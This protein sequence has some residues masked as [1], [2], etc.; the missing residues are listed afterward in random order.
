MGGYIQVST[1][2]ERREDAEE[3]AKVLIE[4][5][6]AG[7]VQMVG[8]V[9]STYRWKGKVETAEEWLILV[10]SREELYGELEKA[11]EE[12]HPYE[13]PEI[14]ATPIVAGNKGYLEWLSEVLGPP[15]EQCAGDIRT[16]GRQIR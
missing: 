5:R 1:T 16:M 12:V 11:I 7:C 9:V 8:P 4:R 14:I 13:T 6:L 10:K 15:Q 2:V 3:I